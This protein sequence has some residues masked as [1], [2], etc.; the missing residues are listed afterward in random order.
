MWRA[1][2]VLGIGGIWSCGGSDEPGTS[3]PSEPVF[4]ALAAK[5][6]LPQ[7]VDR[8]LIHYGAWDAAALALAKTHDLVIFHPGGGAWTRAAVAELQAAGVLVLGYVSVGEDDRTIGLGAAA[9][10]ADP[11]FTGDRSGPRTDPRGPGADG[12]P[13]TNLPPLGAPSPGGSGFASWYLD[14]VDRD[15]L[16]DSNAEFGGAFVN[17]GDPKWFD[18][19]QDMTLDGPDRKAGLREILTTSHGRG[20]GCDGVFMDTFDTAAPNRWSSGSKFEWTAAGFSAFTKRLRET[21]PD[22]LLLQNR[23]MFFFHPGHPHYRV[24]TRPY[25]DF[26]FYESYRLNSTP[27]SSLN[28][29]PVHYPANRHVYAPK[30]MA[31]A[32]RPDGFRVLSLGYAAGSP[33]R[34]SELT[35]RGESTLGFDSLIEDIRV[36]QELAGFRHYL[37]N[38]AVNSVNSF[39]RDH[40]NFADATPPAWSSTWNSSSS[41][42]PVPRV[43]IQQAVPGAGAV[44]VRWD[45][46]LDLHPVRYVLDTRTPGGSDSRAPLTPSIGAGYAEAFGPSTYAYEAQVTGLTPGQAY[47]FRIRA[48]DALGNEDANQVVLSATPSGGTSIGLSAWRASNGVSDVTY[49]FGFEGAW[50]WKRT[51]IDTDRNAGTGF[52]SSRL[53]VGAEFLL[54]NSSLYRYTGS[55]SSWSW[56]FVAPAPAVASGTD[57][58]QWTFAQASLGSTTDVDLVFHVER[59]GA[60]EISPPYRHVY[61]P[62]DPASPFYGTYAENDAET[63]RYHARIRPVWTWRQVFIDEDEEAATGY[64][65]GGIGAGYLI[66]N[67]RLYR[68]AGP[69]WAWAYL[70]DA[71]ESVSGDSHLWWVRRSDLGETRG[72]ERSRL[73]FHGNGGS[74]AAASALYT[75][76]YSP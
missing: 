3:I 21:Y 74:P 27:D 10:R 6:A 49:R 54:E 62:T 28:P 57:S 40:S 55:G 56:A 66:E 16:P 9:L 64:A 61:S 36:T 35:L 32:G 72:L 23:G 47:E 24:T 76:V 18:V 63:I 34:M 73:R 12:Q 29:H 60:F 53:G 33:D 14:D 75:H 11:R 39:V 17:A 42:P 71:H 37:S 26:A 69:G 50:T 48:V 67:G 15:G 7:G 20:L 8:Y 70:G 4:A 25:I 30:V 46:A 1:A 41:L 65:W 58:I 45:V 38:P 43:G 59:S 5:S 52:R 44:T 68:H 31:E 51:W 19:L 13:L 22:R 2:L